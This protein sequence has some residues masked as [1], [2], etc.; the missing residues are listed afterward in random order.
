M[1]TRKWEKITIYYNDG[2]QLTIYRHEIERLR[3][4]EEILT[5][6]ETA[7]NIAEEFE[8]FFKRG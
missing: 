3:R 7:R 4:A 2:E 5:I 6:L 8:H 1:E